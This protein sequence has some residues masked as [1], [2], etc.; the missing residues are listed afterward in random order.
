MGLFSLFGIRRRRLFRWVRRVSVLLALLAA[1]ATV[2]GLWQPLATDMPWRAFGLEDTALARRV[3]SW[4]DGIVSLWPGG[5]VQGPSQGR[6]AASL[7]GRA[8]V[9]DGDSLRVRGMEVRLHGIDAPE[10]RQTCRDG[11][12]RTYA[13]GHMAKLHL[14]RLVAGRTVACRRVTTDRYGRMVALCMAG[15]EDIGR[16]MVREGWAVAFVR[17]SRHYVNDERAARRARRG[18]WQGRFVPPALWRR[19]HRKQRRR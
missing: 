9:I 14:Q 10:L 16:R 2:A 4:M 5:R 7:R 12:G 1:P 18:L 15:G 8:Q 13:C 3:A 11:R 6:N 19:M 17:Y